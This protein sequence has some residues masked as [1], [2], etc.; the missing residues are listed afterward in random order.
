[1]RNP[2]LA[3]PTLGPKS[4]CKTRPASVSSAA[5]VCFSCS[6]RFAC[7]REALGVVRSIPMLFGVSRSEFGALGGARP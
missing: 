4:T 7:S 5:A 3:A 2:V 6:Q 1:M